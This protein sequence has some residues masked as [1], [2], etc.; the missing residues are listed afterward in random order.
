MKAKKKNAWW[1]VGAALVFLL[2]K[3]KVIL[4][5]LKLGKFGGV[6]ISMAISVW[7]YTII[8]PWQMAVGIVVMLLIHEL[9]H[10]IAARMK[11]LPAS[12]PIFIP[13]LGA[14]I[15]MKRHPKDALTEAF[16]AIGGPVL[17]SAGALLA[18]VIGWYGNI[19]VLIVIG[20]LGI[21]LNLI[22]LLPVHPLDGGRIVTAVTRWLWLVGLVGGLAVIIYLRSIIFFIIWA[23]FAWDLYNKYVRGRRNGK[24]YKLADQ[25]E[26]PIEELLQQ[27]MIIPGEEHK[28]EL[29]FTTY[30]T[31]EDNLQHV[32]LR[33]EG[34]GLHAKK[35]LQ[36]Q[37]IVRKAQVTAVRR[38]PQDNPTHIVVHYELELELYENDRYFDVPTWARWV[39]GTAYFGL[40]VLL[41]YVM[42][43]LRPLVSSLIGQM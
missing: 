31:I 38:L 40:A 10:V 16:V 43:G 29:P 19:P 1:A 26:L 8:A 5:L 33:W 30:T 39:Y 14:L 21:F 20:N 11:G 18:I 13:F 25:V 42:L 22:N 34:L 27:G 9:G 36:F 24:P 23:M 2:S 35:S 37:S 41:V 12:A 7:A 3:A 17:G 32:E 15:N 28:R 4:P 6:L